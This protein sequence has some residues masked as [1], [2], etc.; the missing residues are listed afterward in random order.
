VKKKKRV[1]K[2]DKEQSQRFIET[3]KILEV[4]ETGKPFD[5][6]FKE[7]TKKTQGETKD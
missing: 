6:A 5:R 4:N 7:I 2:D 3:A 1:R